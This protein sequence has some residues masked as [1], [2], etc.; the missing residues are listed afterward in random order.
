MSALA[1][2][3]LT[4]GVGI[5]ALVLITVLVTTVAYDTVVHLRQ[6]DAKRAAKAELVEVGRG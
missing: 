4:I 1:A 3:L 6:R 5:I 2:I